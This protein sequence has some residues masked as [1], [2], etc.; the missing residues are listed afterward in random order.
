VG[1]LPIRQEAKEPDPHETAWQH[2]QEKP[3]KFVGADRQGPHLAA[4]A[5]VLPPER[6]RAV[7]DVDDSMV[8]DSDAVASASSKCVAKQCR[9]CGETIAS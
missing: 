1:S 2:V 6:D 8:G 9:A 3:Q 4:V 5:V 7:R